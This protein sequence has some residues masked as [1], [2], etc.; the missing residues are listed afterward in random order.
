MIRITI[1]NGN[2]DYNAHSNEHDNYN[3]AN[4]NNDHSYYDYISMKILEVMLL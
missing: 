1:I 3:V 4:S 2:R